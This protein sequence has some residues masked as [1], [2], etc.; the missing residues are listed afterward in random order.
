MEKKQ[1]S[2][3]AHHTFLERIDELG[4]KLKNA[5]MTVEDEIQSIG[6]FNGYADANNIEQLKLIPGVASVKIVDNE[7]E[8]ERD[9]YS[10][11]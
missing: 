8:S 6:H 1:I 3:Q 5:G 9:E 2:V 11:D 10:I 4:Q 7:E